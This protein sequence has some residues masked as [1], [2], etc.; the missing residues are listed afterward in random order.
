MRWPWIAERSGVASAHGGDLFDGDRGVVTV[1]LHR[2]GPFRLSP[3]RRSACVDL[4]DIRHIDQRKLRW[5][6]G[7]PRAGDLGLRAE[8]ELTE[9]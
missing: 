1:H 7:P 9:V 4:C 6:V 8:T 2:R 3:F 5:R